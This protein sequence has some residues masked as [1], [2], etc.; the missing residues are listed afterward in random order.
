MPEGKHDLM[1]KK[2]LLCLG[3]LLVA[4]GA[5]GIVLPVLPTTPFLLLAAA[6]FSGSSEKAY[7]FLLKSPLFGPF[8]QHY[9]TGQGV[10]IG[11]KVQAI[12]TLWALLAAGAY[13]MQKT[14]AYIAFPIIGAAVTCHLLLIKTAKRTGED[15]SVSDSPQREQ[16]GKEV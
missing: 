9:K 15:R 10:S 12:A 5:V 6:C 11:R 4:L 2:L 16:S 3:W 13:A 14:W 1:K 7:R 8:I